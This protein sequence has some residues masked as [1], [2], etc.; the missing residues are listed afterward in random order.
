MTSTSKATRPNIVLIMVDDMGF[1]DIGCY[2][3]EISTPN[4]DRLAAGGVR[5]SQFYNYARCCP[6]RASLLTGLYPHQ[7]GVGFMVTDFGLPGYRGFLNNNCVTIAEAL[8]SSGYNTAMSGKWHVGGD[9]PA[10]KWQN[11]CIGDETHPTPRQRGFDKFY[12]TLAGSGNFFDPHSL[13][14]NDEVIEPDNYGD[15]Y[16]T[17]AIAENAAS[18]V[19]DYADK[20]NPF[21]LYVGFTA[22]HWPLHAL[23]EDIER[24][25]GEYRKGWDHLRTSRH[26]ELKAIGILQDD[27]DITP[28]DKNSPPWEEVNDKSWEDLRMAVYAAQVDRMDQG[29]GKIMAALDQ[30]EVTQ[31][32]LVMFLSDNGGCAELL[33]EDGIRETAP[34]TTRSGTTVRSG[35]IAGLDPGDETTY[36]SYDLPWANASNSPFKLY[37]HWTHEGGIATP[38]IAHWPNF[39]QAGSINHSIGH[40]IDV[41]ATC[42]DAADADYPS[43]YNDH[44]ITPMQ[45]QSL[46]PA[47]SNA[48]I[49]R[50]RPIM[51]EHEGNRAVRIGDWKLVNRHPR[52]WELYNMREDRTELN[53]L[54]EK[55]PKRV[56]AMEQIYKDW[57][58][59]SEV[60]PWQEIVTLPAAARFTKWLPDYENDTG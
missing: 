18:F 52:G 3:A 21:F 17:D 60:R 55:D 33:E 45:G 27:W 51:W 48:S 14:S 53:D 38:F 11:I 5:F 1:S 2:G 41:M 24:Y 58:S 31:D 8:K 50:E 37:K 44:A 4:L 40:V 59:R 32:T 6:T 16:Y 42:L 56:D 7:A 15:Y 23:E 30:A 12:G 19:Q 54:A 49:E 34:T 22:P 46:L 29:I 43:E 36:M 47:F 57:A 39:A 20:E 13:M 28:R 10:N 26:E 25:R 9:Y 35:N